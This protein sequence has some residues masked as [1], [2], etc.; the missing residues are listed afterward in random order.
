MKNKILLIVLGIVLVVNILNIVSAVSITNVI[1][2]PAEIIPGQIADVSI[3]V[4]NIFDYDVKNIRLKLD[5]TESPFAPYQS[6]SEKFLDELNDGDEEDFNFKLIV[7]PDTQ[8]G[9]YKIPIQ[10]MY[11]DN[12]GTNITKN[13][14]IS[15]IVNSKPELKISIEDSVIIKGD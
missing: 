6:S 9:I 15:L 5:L 12:N 4:E 7:L 2:S 13:E 3:E 8:S 14:V 11:S 1:S 10:I